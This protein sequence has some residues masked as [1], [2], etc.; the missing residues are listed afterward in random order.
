MEGI[1]FKSLKYETSTAMCSVMMVLLMMA[2]GRSID[3]NIFLL[4]SKVE[5]WERLRKMHNV[6][7]DLE[8]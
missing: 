8:N 6:E 5:R 1:Y 4:Q 2:Q 7:G 3:Q